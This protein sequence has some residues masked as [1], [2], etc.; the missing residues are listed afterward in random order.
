MNDER[1][2]EAALLRLLGPAAFLRLVEAYGGVRLFVPETNDRTE[3]VAEIGNDAVM[4]LVDRWGG[5]YIRVP[6]AREFRARQYRAAGLSNAQI[7]RRLGMAETGVNKLFGRMENVP[8]KGS[9]DPRQLPL[10][11]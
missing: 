1:A 4:K 5:F 10:F 8:V 9:G 11:K 6:L 2:S 7:A 3:L